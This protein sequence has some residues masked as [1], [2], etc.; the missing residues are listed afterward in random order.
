MHGLQKETKEH[1][2]T[3]RNQMSGLITLHK[4][5]AMPVRLMCDLSKDYHEVSS[6]KFSMA[7]WDLIP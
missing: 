7:S 4:P 6:P 1:K 2:S 5:R 3:A